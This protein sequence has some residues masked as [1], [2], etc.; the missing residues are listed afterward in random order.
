MI[1]AIRRHTAQGRP[2]DF[3]LCDV[4]ERQR[5]GLAR[6]QLAKD[7][8]EEFGLS[9]AEALQLASASTDI[10]SARRQFIVLLRRENAYL[11]KQAGE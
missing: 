2:I 1:N 7:I 4:K 6:R 9:E 11:H 3:S 8:Q 5:R 10:E